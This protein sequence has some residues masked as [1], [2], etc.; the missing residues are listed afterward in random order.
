MRRSAR[1]L[2]RWESA[3]HTTSTRAMPTA[4]LSMSSA[5]AST[6]PLLLVAKPNGSR[7]MTLPAKI[8]TT[9]RDE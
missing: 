9:Q 8:V 1:L 6:V 4:A 7:S 3:T 2:A 5:T